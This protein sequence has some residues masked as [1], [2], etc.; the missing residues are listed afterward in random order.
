MGILLIIV[1]VIAG[2]LFGFGFFPGLVIG[3]GLGYLT[4]AF[5]IA[6]RMQLALQRI[7]G[8]F[9]EAFADE[10]D[11]ER[12]APEMLGRWARKRP[13]ITAP[14]D[15]FWDGFRDSPSWANGSY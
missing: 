7:G 4:S 8:A 11:L 12:P 3:F 1:G 5:V 14:T 15:R 6:V 10:K 9:A 13:A 2:I